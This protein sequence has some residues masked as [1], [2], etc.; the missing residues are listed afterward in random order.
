MLAPDATPGRRLRLVCDDSY[1]CPALVPGPAMASV[2][3]QSSLRVQHRNSTEILAITY[4]ASGLNCS[5]V[6]TMF[7]FEVL[8]IS[9]IQGRITCK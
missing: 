9:Y 7:L 4:P 1:I 5:L 3:T 8:A 2:Q 6:L